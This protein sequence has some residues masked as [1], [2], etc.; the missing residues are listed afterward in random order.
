MFDHSLLTQLT[1][2]AICEGVQQFAVGAVIQKDGK[3]LILRRLPDDFM[4]G[5]YELPSGKVE[6]NESLDKALIREVKEETGLDVVAIRSYIDSFDYTGR[7]GKKSRQFNFAVDVNTS[8]PIILEEHD[9]YEWV[10]L[11]GELPVTE[12]VKEVLRKFQEGS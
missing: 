4:G 6:A 7:S 3:V 1:D 5:I 11:T 9:L 10:A 12:T 8:D 2:Q